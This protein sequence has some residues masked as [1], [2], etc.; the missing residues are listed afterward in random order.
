MPQIGTT[1]GSILSKVMDTVHQLRVPSIDDPSSGFK[2]MSAGV[3]EE[4]LAECSSLYSEPNYESEH[5]VSGAIRFAVWYR[6][7]EKILYIKIVN[8]CGLAAAKGKSISPY[9]KVHLLPDKSK[10]TKRK[11]GIQR[12]TT[13]PDYDEIVKV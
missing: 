10:H 6:N 9:V 8:A 4:N 2:L 7:D 5:R 12:K 11:T 3:S 1:A 13:D